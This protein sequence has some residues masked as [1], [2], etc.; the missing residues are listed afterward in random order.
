MIATLSQLFKKF[1]QLRGR[2]VF[3]LPT[4]FGILY[5]AFL[6][7]IL[8]SAINYSNSLGHILCFLLASMGVLAMHY[9]YNNLA[10]IEF[11][12]A[13][14]DPVFCGQAIQFKLLFDNQ[15]NH[16]CY[17]IDV[18]SKQNNVKSWNPFKNLTGFNYQ[19]HHLIKQLTAQQQQ[20]HTITVNSKK[21]G[22]QILGQI[23]IAS[24]FPFGLFDTWSYFTSNDNAI[25]YPQA[26]GELSLPLSNEQGQYAIGK[27]IK[28]L[29]D[30]SG[31]NLYRAGDPIHAIAWKAA[32]RDD[33]L[34]TKQFS[35][36]LSGNI[37]LSWQ[38][39]AQL[40]NTEDR[41]S[42]LCL[43]IIE[44]EAS[45]LSYALDLPTDFLH[46]GHGPHHQ[47]QCL[48]ALALYEH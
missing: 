17:L 48:T 15:S 42:Q 47:Q 14:A 44:C 3:I 12:S 7:L 22:K 8:L 5:A 25:V 36:T 18:G 4:R 41:L 16:D 39:T 24:R 38:A 28:G 34:R 30:F 13:H 20:R 26:K 10:K 11:L 37:L 19:S 46:Y 23:R 6:F 45:G 33:I 29:D 40:S 1:N 35:S 27:R 32:A 31:F 43:W 2:R 9:T 21:R